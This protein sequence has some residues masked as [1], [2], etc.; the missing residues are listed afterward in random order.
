MQVRL[1]ELSLAPRRLGVWRMQGKAGFALVDQ[2]EE[3]A[4][5]PGLQLLASFRPAKVPVRALALATAM[6]RMAFGDDSGKVSS[7]T[8]SSS[9]LFDSGL[10]VTVVHSLEGES[11][12]GQQ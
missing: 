10:R 7:S 12:H 4:A 5:P 9:V 1:Y 6:R 2:E 8:D 11:K 3:Q